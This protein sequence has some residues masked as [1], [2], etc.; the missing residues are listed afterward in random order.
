MLTDTIAAIA[1]P[2]GTGGLA[3]VRISGPEAFAIADKCFVPVGKHSK[4]PSQAPSH[5]I[6]YGKIVRNDQTIDEVLLAVMH[7]PRTYTREHVV[8]IMCHGGL[9]PAKMVLETI[10]AN[11]ARLAEPGE[12]TK[13]AFINGRIDLTQAEA[14][15]DLIHARTELAVRAANEQLAGHLS[16]R[17]NKLYDE[18]LAVLAHVEAQLDFP[19]DDIEPATKT[20]LLTKLNSCVTEINQLLR[21][22][23]EGQ[24][25]RQGVRAVI[26]GRPNVGKSSLLNRLLGHDRAIV[27]HIPGTTRDT[28]EETANIR[29]LPVVLVDTAGLRDARDLVEHEGVKRT[30]TA[31]TTAELVLHVLD[32]SEELTPDDKSYLTEFASKKRVIIIN[33]TDLPRR[34][35]L[36]PQLLRA[37]SCTH[38]TPQPDHSGTPV[39][40]ISCLTGAGIEQL[41]DTIKELIWS[42]QITA[43]MLQV[44]INARHQQALTRAHAAINAA[45]ESLHADN[46]LELTA[47][48]LRDAI[49]ALG[50]ITGKTVTEDLLDVIFS[51]FCIGK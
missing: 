9:L 25:L 21:T 40:E 49:T 37:N 12:F 28:I 17:I 27:S 23:N 2:I 45:I 39:V 7:A 13:R 30:R 47:I 3:I 32:G 48:D 44:T 19:E 34:L 29:G 51:Q 36:P 42:G 24:I 50:E 6:Q 35:S 38:T 33:K 22:A 8:E 11:G 16:R 41:K 26:V 18:L 1:T 43:E 20:Q 14:V 10:L 46:R 31:L 4:K 5:T 15:I